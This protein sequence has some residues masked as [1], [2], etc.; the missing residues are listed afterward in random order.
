MVRTLEAIADRDLAAGE[1]DEG[2]GDEEG[3]DPAGAALLQDQRGLGDGVEAADART[4]HHPGPLALLLG[5]E[6]DA[7][8]RDRL[9]GG[10]H[11]VDDELVVAAELLRF[12]EVGGAEQALAIALGHET[13]HLGRQVTDLEMLDP[14]QPGTPGEE[15][16]PYRLDAAPQRGDEAHPGDDHAPHGVPAPLRAR[17]SLS[18]H[19]P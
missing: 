8:V 4:D 9:G 3:A 2:R 19:A 7:R 12:H 1:V 14:A 5:L 11:A 16:G 15:P 17:E 10:T 6:A 18:S 13:R